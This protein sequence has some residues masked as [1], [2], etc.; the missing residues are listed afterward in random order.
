MYKAKADEALYEFSGL[1]AGMFL[2]SF[3]A[4]NSVFILMRVSCLSSEYFYMCLNDVC[5]CVSDVIPGGFH[6]LEIMCFGFH[7]LHI[8]SAE[9]WLKVV[10]LF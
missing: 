3:N 6:F 8:A 5:L 1:L 7:C 9:C 10:L 2:H 4:L